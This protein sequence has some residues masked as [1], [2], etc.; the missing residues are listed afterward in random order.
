ML[1]AHPQIAT[2]PETFF[3][4]DLMP[5]ARR[6]LLL[7]LPGPQARE[8][9]DRIAAE[10][11]GPKPPTSYPPWPVTRRALSRRFVAHLD[12]VALGRGKRAWVEKTPSHLHQVDAI[13]RYV[14][15][16]RIVHI[17]RAGEAASASLYAVTQEHPKQWGRARTFEECVD[18]WRQDLRRTYA[19]RGRP[20]HAFVS[21][22]RLVADPARVL[23][24]L[25]G[26]IGLDRD[27]STIDEILSG[28]ARQVPKVVNDEP[29]KDGV[30]APLVNRNGVRLDALLSAR[31]QRE[32]GDRLAPERRLAE[33]LPYLGGAR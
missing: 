22:E 29:W 1:A 17:V 20:N 16:A 21:Y 26:W 30:E 18:R 28:Y 3:F 19:C 4:V 10:I 12:Q 5:H 27:P 9:L 6:R 24:E 32:L 14:G 8:R 15:A 13:E 2:F 7:G 11:P 31:E 25:I 23:D 33:R